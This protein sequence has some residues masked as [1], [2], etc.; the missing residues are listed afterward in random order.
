MVTSSRP[1]RLA[2][3]A[4]SLLILF[5]LA[6]GI[7]SNPLAGRRTGEVPVTGASGI[8]DVVLA[9]SVGPNNQ[10]QDT[11][12]TFDRED[13]IIYVVA[14]I[15]RID[16]GTSVFARWSRNGRPFEDTPTITADREYT[17]TYLE[18]HIQSETGVFE[19][20]DYSVT[21]YVNGNPA[22]TEEFAVR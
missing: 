3:S 12:N 14:E 5:S 11:T 15:D 13:P 6:C 17:D 21:L 8:G 16:A 20:G 4:L 9:R 10:P 22:A 2:V 1:H 19:P 7:C 18:F